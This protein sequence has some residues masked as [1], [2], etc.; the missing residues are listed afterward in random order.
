MEDL[1][2][3]IKSLEADLVKVG[4]EVNRAD[5]D[6]RN[7]AERKRAISDNLNFRANSRKVE[8]LKHEI[9]QLESHNAAADRARYQEEGEK[10]QEARNALSA[11]QA[12]LSGEIKSKDIQLK[13]L[14]DEF[15]KDYKDATTKH[16]LAQVELLVKGKIVDDLGVFGKAMDQGIM[17]YHG[18][19]MDQ[20]NRIIEELWRK[21][22]RGTDVDTILIRSEHDGAKGNK[23]YNYRVVM[24]KQDAEMDMRGRCSAGQKVLASIIIRLALAECFSVNCGLIA[25]DE[26]TTNLDRDNIRSLATSLNELIKVRRKQ[27]NFQLIV[28]THDEEFLRY[29]N[30]AELCDEYFRVSRSDKQ[31]SSIMKQSI[32][33]VYR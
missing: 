24:V 26:P 9:S 2:A 4:R 3:G 33:E 1:E 23:S 14:I 7:N 32:S 25:L 31:K 11:E 16:Q 21:T 18:A 22:Y 6:L 20:V 5:K 12:S 29:M 28:I 17:K 8:G 30:C 10:W 13:G 15:K 19:R 27:A